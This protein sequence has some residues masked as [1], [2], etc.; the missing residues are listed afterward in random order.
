MYISYVY[1]LFVILC[2]P[3]RRS[4]LVD[5]DVDGESIKMDIQQARWRGLGWIDVA[6]DR[7]RRRTF[8]NVVMYLRVS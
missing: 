1:V 7:D 8:L 5:L 4:H 2:V 6:Q 3:G